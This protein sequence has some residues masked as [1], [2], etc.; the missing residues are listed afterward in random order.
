MKYTQEATEYLLSAEARWGEQSLENWHCVSPTVKLLI[1]KTK[2]IWIQKLTLK[3]HLLWI[4]AGCWPVYIKALWNSDDISQWPSSL[5]CRGGKQQ[6][7]RWVKTGDIEQGLAG[8][9]NLRILATC[10]FWQHRGQREGS[11]LFSVWLQT[12][13]GFKIYL[14]WPWQR[15]LCANHQVELGSLKK[16]RGIK[17]NH[18]TE[19]KTDKGS[20]REV[21]FRHWLLLLPI[22][23]KLVTKNK[24]SLTLNTKIRPGFLTPG[25]TGF[26]VKGFG[27]TN[28]LFHWRSRVSYLRTQFELVSLSHTFGTRIEN[29]KE[30][31]C[32]V[33]FS[34]YFPQPQSLRLLQSLQ[35]WSEVS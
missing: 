16:E 28:E 11:T 6:E 10:C 17:M 25:S 9:K 31:C 4:I 26:S 1:Q 18:K 21:I 14:Q 27:V 22:K 23:S 7:R 13:R 24:T 19:N 20:V 15:N 35:W 32:S 33:G 2:L 5:I 3:W 12:M 34:R 8:V 29:Q 30:L